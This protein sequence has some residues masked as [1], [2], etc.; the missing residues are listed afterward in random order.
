MFGKLKC[1]VAVLV[2]VGSAIADPNASNPIPLNGA[3]EV[4]PDVV[5]NWM[6]GQ[7]AGNYVPGKTGDGH[8]VFFH[9]NQ[10]WVTGA[11]LGYPLGTTYGHYRADVNQWSPMDP[12]LGMGAAPQSQTTYYWRVI[13]VNSVAAGSPWKGSVWS[14]T[15]ISS[16]AAAPIPADGAVVGI[17]T[18]DVLNIELEWTPGI[19][20]ESVDGHDVYLG[21]DQAAVTNATVANGLGVYQGRQSAASYELLDLP[22]DV[23]YYWRIDEVNNVFGVTKGDVWHFA[24]DSGLA[25]NPVPANGQTGVNPDLTIS[26][27]AGFAAAS[28]NIYFGTDAN[29]LSA[30]VTGYPS[31][32]YELGLNLDTTYYWRIDEVNATHP[33]SPWVG[34]VWS[35]T[36]DSGKAKNPSP[37]NGQA[38]VYLVADLSWTASPRAAWH[39]VYFGTSSSPP[40]VGGQPPS[41]TTFDP[42]RLSYGVTYYWRIDTEQSSGE[43]T[44]GD[45]WS[46][47]AAAGPVDA[48]VVIDQS[49]QYQTIDGFGAHGARNVYWSNPSSWYT[50]AW[51]NLIVNDLGLTITRNAYHP[52]GSDTT[53]AAQKPFLQ[54]LKQKADQS[55]EPLKFISTFWSPPGYMK[56]NG[57]IKNGGHVLPAYYDDLGNYAVGAI[58]D[59]KNAGIDLYALSLQNEPGFAEPYD[60]CV[61]THEE[62]RDMLKIAGPIINASFPNTKLFMCEHMLGWQY[63]DSQAMEYDTMQDPNAL[64]WADIWA[65]HG[66]GNDGQ[67]PDPG[68]AEAEIWMIARDRFEPTGRHF[69]MTETSGYSE[70]WADSRQLAQSIFA[71]LKYGRV[72]AWVWWQLSENDGY[73]NPPGDYVLMNLDTPGKRYYISKQFYRYIRP[74]AVMVDCEADNSEVLVAAFKHPVKKTATIVLINTG[75]TEKLVQLDIAGDII[76]PKFHIYRTTATENCI[77]AGVVASDGTFILPESSVTTLYAGMPHN[78][79]NDFAGFAAQWRQTGCNAG[80]NW[81]AGADSNHNGSV[82]LDDLET[83]ADNWL[84]N[85]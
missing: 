16:K 6:P 57:S 17:Y 65:V 18:G 49:I 11:G 42:G 56:D 71:A 28:H 4:Y 35:F 9:T 38:G 72:S 33:K 79:F 75:Q 55:G 51:L 67:T 40:F 12:E 54:A 15:T 60:S 78:N 82:L 68:S 47:T 30:V 31:T 45:E 83:F 10:S 7:Y 59:Y 5:L 37:G 80:N 64:Q 73:G 36:T 85:F 25:K 20:A 48:N 39:N 19:L 74:E 62:Y 8:H 52:P 27:T 50:D 13:E 81:C 76:P 41:V 70:S 43:T 63:N 66:Y 23:N 61:Y 44:T 46:F 24:T 77:N 14:L 53:F 58:Q 21:T 29:A 34:N 22:L 1:L 32:S 69:W 3:S 2:L 26:W 84:L